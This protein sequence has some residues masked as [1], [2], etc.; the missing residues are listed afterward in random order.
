[1]LLV[2]IGV[3]PAYGWSGFGEATVVLGAMALATALSMA[4][5]ERISPTAPQP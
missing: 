2:G 4:L 5:M 3:R 1:V